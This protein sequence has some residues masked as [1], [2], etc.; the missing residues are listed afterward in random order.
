MFIYFIAICFASFAFARLSWEID[1]D[2]K[3]GKM[4]VFAVSR[5]T[6]ISIGQTIEFAGSGNIRSGEYT[7]EGFSYANHN[8]NFK[9]VDDES[10]KISLSSQRLA[11]LMHDGKVRKIGNVDFSSMK[12]MSAFSDDYGDIDYYQY[13]DQLLQQEYDELERISRLLRAYRKYGN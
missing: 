2:A 1:Y 5:K 4:D 12:A 13:Q 10:I 9:K 8:A 7:F 6:G 11:Q 3:A